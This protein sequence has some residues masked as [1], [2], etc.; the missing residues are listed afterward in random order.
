MDCCLSFNIRTGV[1]VSG[2]LCATDHIIEKMS[3]ENAVDVFNAVKKIRL[4][5]PR[6]IPTLVSH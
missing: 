1:T 6:F 3:T 5:Q 2:L 4:T